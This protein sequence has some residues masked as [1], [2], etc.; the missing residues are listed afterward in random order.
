MANNSLEGLRGNRWA[1]RVLSTTVAACAWACLFTYAPT[2][3]GQGQGKAAMDV[4]KKAKMAP[5]SKAAAPTAKQ[6]SAHPSW[7][8]VE[9][10]RRD[11]FLVPPPTKPGDIPGMGPETGPLPP[12][13]RGLVISQLVLEGIV[14]QET[15]N[16]MI[17]VVNNSSNRAYFLRENDELYNGVVNK[18]TPDSVQFTEN[19]R[20][21]NG[22]MNSRQ[23]VK[24]LGSGPG[25]NR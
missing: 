7:G 16:T 15:S 5:A 22:Q 3:A 8:P 6:A 12:G 2:V 23:V 24:Q 13:K 14:R 18:I 1:T 17:A 11:P 20:D 4:A 9:G 25:E 10:G 19:F 21:L